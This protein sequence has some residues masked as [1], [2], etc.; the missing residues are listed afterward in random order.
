MIPYGF[1]QPQN[2][3]CKS[4]QNNPVFKSTAYG[5]TASLK[6]FKL[7]SKKSFNVMA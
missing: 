1:I 6:P 2:T 7:L 3:S 4:Q 5:K